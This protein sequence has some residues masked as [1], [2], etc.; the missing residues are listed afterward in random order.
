[1]PAT[2][3]L[4]WPSRSPNSVAEGPSWMRHIFVMILGFHNSK[5]ISS[6][7][8]GLHTPLNTSIRPC[9]ANPCFTQLFKSTTTSFATTMKVPVINNIKKIHYMRWGSKEGMVAMF[10]LSNISLSCYFNLGPLLFALWK[11]NDFLKEK[12][13]QN[14]LFHGVGWPFWDECIDIFR[15]MHILLDE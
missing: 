2:T 10:F 12:N 8:H 9:P 3:Y 13:C 4:S 15:W 1:M 14:L 5:W 6:D 7:Y 11:I